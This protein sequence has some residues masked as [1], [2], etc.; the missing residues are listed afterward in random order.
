MWSPLPVLA[1]R[2]PPAAGLEV[3]FLFGEPPVYAQLSRDA[4]RLNLR[5]V[6][7]PVVDRAAAECSELLA[8]YLE[9]DGVAALYR[10]YAAGDVDFYRPLGTKPWGI[11]GFIVRDPDGN[12]FN[13]SAAVEA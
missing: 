6:D 13:F 8:A 12:P 4:A 1:P 3:R 9:V 2:G 10:E 7:T 5:L 11:V